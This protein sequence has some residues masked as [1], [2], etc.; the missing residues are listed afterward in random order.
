MARSSMT[1]VVLGASPIA[2]T[3]GNNCN[4]WTLANDVLSV[5]RLRTAQLTCH[6]C[7]LLNSAL[8]ICHHH[9]LESDDLVSFTSL[10]YRASVSHLLYT[11]QHQSSISSTRC[12]C[13]LLRAAKSITLLFNCQSF[14]IYV[15]ID[16]V[17]FLQLPAVDFFVA[18]L[19]CR[20][21]FHHCL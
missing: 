3:S 14:C 6:V 10:Q 16:A 12:L 1:A 15:Q 17:F 7:H 13:G 19:L 18:A 11:A 9:L 2:V 4:W 5:R 8:L 20:F 21:L